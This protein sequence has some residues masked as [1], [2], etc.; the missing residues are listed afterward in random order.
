M[1]FL[2]TTFDGD[3][4]V[5]LYGFATDRYCLLGKQKRLEKVLKVDFYNVTIAGT[6]LVGLF[7]AGNSQGIVLPKIVQEREIKTIKAVGLNTLVIKSKYTAIGNLVVCNDNGCIISGHLKKFR[8]EIADTLGCEVEIG[9][10]SG[11]SI[12]GS[13]AVANNRG[14]LCNMNA[15]EE[16]IEVIEQVLKVK[17]DVGSIG[18]SPFVKSGMIINKNGFVVSRDVTGPELQRIDEVFRG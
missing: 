17:A 16:E 5:G 18:G 7:S 12:V 11:L 15:K 6:E 9:K 10:I 1:K 4:N 8:K 3:P 14:C 2:R 13:S